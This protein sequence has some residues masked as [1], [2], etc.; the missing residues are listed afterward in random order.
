MLDQDGLGKPSMPWYGNPFGIRTYSH[1]LVGDVRGPW[2]SW[3]SRNH[4]V[5]SHKILPFDG[6]WLLSDFLET[7]YE[8]STF[9]NHNRG[10]H[11]L[12]L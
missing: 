6:F 4:R 7:S 9:S 1:G 8:G 11:N 12:S 2:P 3:L 10:V 5:G